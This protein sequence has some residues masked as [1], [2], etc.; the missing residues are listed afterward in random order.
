MRALS[1]SM[2]I[3]LSAAVILGSAAL[4]D[5]GMTIIINNNT[6]KNLLV[7]VYDLNANPPQKV[8]SSATLNGFASISVMVSA[9]DS[10]QG[11]VSWTATTVDRDM[12]MCGNHDNPGVNDG[13]TVRV[14]ADSSCTGG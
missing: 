1:R 4:G 2:S 12:R 5:N 13:D 3:T 9:D 14:F 7:T 8:A 10:G 6:T 11:H